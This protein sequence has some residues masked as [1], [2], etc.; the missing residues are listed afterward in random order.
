MQRLP[1][2]S[3]HTIYTQPNMPKDFRKRGKRAKKSARE[4]DEDSYVVYARPEETE[5]HRKALG[6][7]D[8]DVAELEEDSHPAP[9]TAAQY[10]DG[11]QQTTAAGKTAE[12]QHAPEQGGFGVQQINQEPE[13]IWPAVDPDTKA[14]FR[15]LE[16]RIIE[17]EEL[18]ARG[19]AKVL[20]QDDENEDEEE[21]GE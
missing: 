15:Q 6:I 1:S 2:F 19:K 12:G 21:D 18:N 4:K 5:Q 11:T 16:D 8:E 17:L 10:E 3:H 20:L 9:A 13:S 14:Y 7:D